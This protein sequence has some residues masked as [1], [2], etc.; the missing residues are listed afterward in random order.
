MSV[1]VVTASRL[2]S[3]SLIGEWIAARLRTRGIDAVARDAASVT[4]V[5]PYSA[6]ILGSGVY[7][8]HWLPD[9][10]AFADRYR[11]A[12]LVRP[13]WLFS[14]GPVGDMATRH[15]T[16]ELAEVGRLRARLRVHG[17]RTFA[18]ALD[19]STLRGADLGRIER[20][21][22]ER[23]VPEGDYRDRAAVEDWADEIAAAVPA[24][25]TA[26]SAR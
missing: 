23:F 13:V 24:E 9:A 5:A 10:T 22:A 6:V 19:R 1:L 7:A 26:V 18:G 4:D 2:G 8:G 12:L 17:H 25:R 15:E 14:S 21:V 16:E 3:T 11:A 20:F